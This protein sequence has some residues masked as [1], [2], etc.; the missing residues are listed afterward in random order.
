MRIKTGMSTEKPSRV[1]RKRPLMDGNQKLKKI[2]RA[3]DLTKN[4]PKNPLWTG[5]NPVNN[6]K[7]VTKIDR[8]EA[9]RT[10]SLIIPEAVGGAKAVAA[11]E[12]DNCNIGF[13]VGLFCLNRR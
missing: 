13:R 7:E 8:G 12:N 11:A 5:I 9:S 3:R 10:G 1:G 2:K 6:W 4:L